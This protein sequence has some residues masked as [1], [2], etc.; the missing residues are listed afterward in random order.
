MCN[1]K[2]NKTFTTSNFYTKFK[3]KVSK[4]TFATIAIIITV[5]DITTLMSNY[6]LLPIIYV[7][8]IYLSLHGLTLSSFYFSFVLLLLFTQVLVPIVVHLIDKNMYAE[9][10]TLNKIFF[11]TTKTK[12]MFGWNIKAN[13]SVATL[14]CKTVFGWYFV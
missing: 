6:W 7:L 12:P 10:K 8:Y 4:I 5:L 2:H 13:V 11:L 1:V 9:N 14:S 3:F